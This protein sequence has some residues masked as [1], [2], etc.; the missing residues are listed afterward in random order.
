MKL[1]TWLLSLVEPILAKL[2][3]SVGFSVVSIVGFNTLIQQL[4]TQLQTSVGSLSGDLLG[5]FMLAGGGTGLGMVMGAITTR[6][7]LWQAQ[8]ATQFLGK[9]PG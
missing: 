9:A 3:L 1:G 4:K 7:L 6:L 2:L 8:K 5:L